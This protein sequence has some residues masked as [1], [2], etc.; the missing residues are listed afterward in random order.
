M[1]SRN[2]VKTDKTVKE[3]KPRESRKQRARATQLGFE[4]KT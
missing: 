1:K 3:Q 4:D 2:I